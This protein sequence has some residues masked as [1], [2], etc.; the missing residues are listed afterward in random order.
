MELIL[1]RTYHVH[2]TNGVLTVNGKPFC[3]TIELP[4]KDNE[5][6]VS[7]IPEGVYPLAKRF[8][9]TL[10]HHL[11][12]Q[13]VPGRSLILIH[14]ANHAERELQGCIAP[15]TTITGEGRG[16]SSRAVFNP[17]VKLVTAALEKGE[18]VTLIIKG[19][20]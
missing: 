2:G 13:Q 3:F 16:D 11:L 7:C 14:K 15:V 4:W 19:S 8:S 18:L 17:L 6:R 12:V 5:A 1:T 10:K 9:V 20:E